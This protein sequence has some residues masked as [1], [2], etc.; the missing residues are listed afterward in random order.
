MK[1]AVVILPTY[2]EKENVGIVIPILNDVAKSV[3]NWK[4]EVLVVDDTSPDK[5]YEVVKALQKKYSFLHLLVNKKKAGLGSAYLKGMAEAF[6]T[7]K[8]DVVFEFDADLSHDPLKIPEFLKKIDEGYDLVVGSRYRP[9]GSIPNN[10]GLHRKFLS[11]FGNITIMIMLLNF[12]IRDWTGGYRAI[13]KKV[14]EAVAPE[15][16]NE[17]FF[18]YTFQIGFLHKAV[19]KGFKITEVPFNFFDRTIGVSK[20][21]PEHFKNTLIFITKVRIEEIITHRIFKFAFVGGVGALVQ[22]SSLQ[23]LRTLFPFQ[24]AFFLS[25]ECAVVSNFIL[26]NLWTFSDRKL[27]ISEIPSKFIQFNFASAGS[28]VIQQVIAFVGQ[29]GIGIFNLFTLPV[30]NYT[31]DTG[32][33]F[34]VSGILIGMFWNFFAYSKFIWKAK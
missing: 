1:K 15:M 2:N 3:K 20:L 26:N 16:D 27:S 32:L 31:V 4:L 12:A 8:A 5:T 10:W 13:T 14:Y 9:G 7:L 30:I 33:I 6:S 25:I 34:A 11:V 22:L 24:L 29:F 19:R 21:G 17:R 23:I 18:G 28:I